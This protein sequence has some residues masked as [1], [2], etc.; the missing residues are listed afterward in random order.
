MYQA[1]GVN[2]L[3]PLIIYIEFLEELYEHFNKPIT[4]ARSQPQKRFKIDLTPTSFTIL[5][6]FKNSG[7]SSLKIITNSKIWTDIVPCKHGQ[8][9][10]PIILG[11]RELFCLTGYIFSPEGCIKYNSS[12]PIVRK[13]INEPPHEMQI[14]ITLKHEAC[15]VKV[16]PETKIKTCEPKFVLESTEALIND[17]RLCFCKILQIN[18]LRMSNFGVVSNG[19]IIKNETFLF[20]PYMD[21]NQ[22]TSPQF[23]ITESLTLQFLIKSKDHFK[24]KDIDTILLFYYLNILV[25]QESNFMLNEDQVILSFVEDKTNTVNEHYLGWCT[26][27][28]DRQSIFMDNFYILASFDANNTNPDYYIYVNETQTLDGVGYYYLSVQLTTQLET[29]AHMA[30]DFYFQTKKWH[31]HANVDQI[32]SK[33]NLNGFLNGTLKLADVTDIVTFIHKNKTNFLSNNFLVVCN[34]AP[35]ISVKCQNAETMRLHL[36]ELEQMPDRRYCSI[37]HRKCY[38]INEYEYDKL[39]PTKY[40][41]VCK[42]LQNSANEKKEINAFPYEYYRISLIVIILC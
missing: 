13:P 32:I 25:I 31:F 10:D 37:L 33:E 26:A 35:K 17:L 3:N 6:N 24:D 36:C 23:N 34:V 39:E 22:T 15:R 30:K 21:T 9:Y 8:F 40:I 18:E 27:N 7:E 19:Y 1:L 42:S 20:L 14:E 11:C 4:Y 16:D 28:G 5:M 38:L 41:R 12:Y 29:K 2:Q